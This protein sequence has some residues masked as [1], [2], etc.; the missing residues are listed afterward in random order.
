MKRRADRRLYVFDSRRYQNATVRRATIPVMQ[1]VIR[2]FS[3]LL[4]ERPG[5]TTAAAAAS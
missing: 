2:L 4:R 1:G 3:W 5:L